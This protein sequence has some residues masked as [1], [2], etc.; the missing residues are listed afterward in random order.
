MVEGI[1]GVSKVRLY[2]DAGYGGSQELV[3]ILGLFQMASGRSIPDFA[4][5]ILCQA[6]P[7]FDGG[8]CDQ[9][10]YRHYLALV[11]PKMRPQMCA[12]YVF[13]TFPAVVIIIS[14]HQRG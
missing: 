3:R 8:V 5:K 11:I 13:F 14:V 4:S 9:I 2:H 12:V 7:S 6:F 1:D 10:S